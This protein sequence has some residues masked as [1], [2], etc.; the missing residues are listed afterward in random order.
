MTFAFYAPGFKGA[1]PASDEDTELGE[2]IAYWI[3]LPNGE[4]ISTEPLAEKDEYGNTTQPLMEQANGDGVVSVY[5]TSPNDLLPGSYSLV[6]QGLDSDHAV[7][8]RFAIE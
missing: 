7:L 1:V 5:W 2:Q 3:N 6:A 4:V 8:T